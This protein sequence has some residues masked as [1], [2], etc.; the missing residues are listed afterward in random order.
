MAVETLDGLSEAGVIELAYDEFGQLMLRS[1]ASGIKYCSVTTVD[2][3]APK[4]E[5]A[6]SGIEPSATCSAATSSRYFAPRRYRGF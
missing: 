3:P 1:V 4:T 6:T 5:C 2:A